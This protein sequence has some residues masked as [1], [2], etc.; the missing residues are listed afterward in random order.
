VK[1]R[2]WLVIIGHYLIPCITFTYTHTG[3][4]KTV[5]EKIVEQEWSIGPLY[6]YTRLSTLKLT[7]RYVTQ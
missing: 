3:K 1:Y 6:M 2:R 7:H 4:Y 5:D